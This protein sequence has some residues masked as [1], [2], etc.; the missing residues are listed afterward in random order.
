MIVRP[1]PLPGLAVI[2]QTPAA[3]AR[4]SFTRLYCR[5]SFLEHG[6]EPVGEQWSVSF[7]RLAGTLRGLHYQAEPH[8]ETKLIRCAAGAVFDVVVDLRADSPT[9]GRC[10]CIELSAR[11]PVML[12]VPPGFAHGF[13]TLQDASEVLYAISPDYVPEAARG[14]RW[15]DPA[16]AIPWPRPPAVIS[17]RDAGLP[18]WDGV[19]V[20]RASAGSRTSSTEA[21]S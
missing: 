7:N 1:T 20:A 4:G 2:E 12:Y 16:L 10:F 21:G 5:R 6:L 18:L 13:L 11:E 3:D 15:N 17:E 8:A 14:V 19:P 9:R